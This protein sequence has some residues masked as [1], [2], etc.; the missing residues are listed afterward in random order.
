MRNFLKNWLYIVSILL[1]SCNSTNES[2][3]P[4]KIKAAVF[5]GNGA[6]PVCVLHTLEALKIDPNIQGDKISSADILAGKLNQYDVLIFP[7]GSGSKELNNL[8]DFNVEIV[9]DFVKSKG[10]GIVGICAGA[11]LLSNE[12]S[13]PSLKLTSAQIIDIEHYNRGRGLIEFELTEEGLE[14]FPELKGKKTFLQY[15]DGPVL[16]PI[17]SN[18]INYIELAKYVTD[19][20]TKESYPAGITPGKTFIFSENVGQ[21]RVFVI[22]GHPESTPG[23][24]WIV[25][26]MVRWV[27]NNKLVGYNEKWIVPEMNDKE[28]LFDSELIAYEKEE[29]WQLFNESPDSLIMAMNNLY[30]IRSRPAVRWNI[31]LLRHQNKKVRIKAAEMLLKTEYTPA[32]NDLKTVLEIENDSLVKKQLNKSIDFLSEF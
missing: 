14:F 6:S 8:G 20:N 4:D 28:I 17:D 31:G 9:N 2:S 16:Q 15:N 12:P 32:L 23:M 11:Y 29:F 27:S 25:P 13:Y 10:K 3:T 24:R 7:G 5:S 1:F 21:G 18:Q 19:I 26:R 30:N 22:A